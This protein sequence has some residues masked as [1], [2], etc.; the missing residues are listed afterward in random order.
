MTFSKPIDAWS[1]ATFHQVVADAQQES[2]TLEFKRSL[3]LTTP[4][5]KQETAKDISAM[6]N[7]AGGWI[8]YGIAEKANAAGINVATTVMPISG[9]AN[10]VQQLEDVVYGNV[11]PRPHFRVKDYAA[12]AGGVLIAVRVEPSSDALHQVTGDGCFYR[13]TDKAARPMLEPE[14]SQAYELIHRR[15][16]G[17]RAMLEQRLGED[18]AL[19]EGKFLVSFMP[20]TLGDVF[21]PAAADPFGPLFK[22]WEHTITTELKPT[23]FGLDADVGGGYFRARIRRDGTVTVGFATSLGEG[24]EP[25]QVL[26]D[27]S[28][29]F[30]VAR[31]LW[32]S[33]GLVAPITIVARADFE[34]EQAVRT[35]GSNTWSPRLLPKLK[36]PLEFSIEQSAQQWRD[37]APAAL[38]R[39]MNRLFETFGEKRCPYFTDGDPVG[40]ESQLASDRGWVDMLARLR[41]Q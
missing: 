9:P 16:T 31:R 38:R 18:R 2:L 3:S 8:L 36:A 41:E 1:E 34:G 14:V 23:N 40:L 21:E 20:H 4:Q 39:L 27:S 17:M 25:L 28:R 37:D 26:R 12:A 6:A 29:A 15:R 33:L 13:R 24:F 10:L 30:I 7:S 32:R 11:V 35:W 5:A 22:S 19:G